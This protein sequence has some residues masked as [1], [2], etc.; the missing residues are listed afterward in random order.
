MTSVLRK[1]PSVD[2]LLKEERVVHWLKDYP[3]PLVLES[4]REV[5]DFIRSNPPKDPLLVD[6]IL[7]RIY[8]KLSYFTSYTLKPLINATG[9][10]IH[11]N[12]GRSPL[13]ER[14]I[15]N[16]NRISRGYSNLEY[17]IEKGQ[18]G[19][20]SDH[21]KR[22][23]NYLTG[24]E[25]SCVFNNNAAA[26]LLCLSA[27]AQGAEVIVSRGELVEIGGS[28]RIPEIMALSGAVLKEVGTTNKTHL[29]DY[30]NAITPNTK[31]IL[32]VHKSNY[33][34]VGFTKEVSA[35]ELLSLNVPVMFDLGSGC[36]SNI[37]SHEPTVL[38]IIKSG[39]DIVTFS[40]DKLLGGPQAGIVA[41]RTK[42]IEKIKKHPLARAV[43][44]DKLALSALEGTL[45]DYVLCKEQEIPT[46]KMLTQSQKVLYKRAERISVALDSSE[47]VEEKAQAGG[48]SLPE[49]DLLT[50]AVV[51]TPR[52]LKVSVF[53][54]MLRKGDPPVIVRVS[55]EKIV[56]DVSTVADAEVS[57]LIGR[58][59]EL[60]E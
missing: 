42:Y 9:I 5:L 4:I 40:G 41:G 7:S 6:E 8:K 14:A 11:T 27:L 30:E 56:I 37:S 54:K 43:R 29:R 19:S 45:L 10:I 16:L 46:V 53:E 38:D 51:F 52:R 23:L 47:I 44:V 13:S 12:L 21:A 24:A 49:E 28:F 26:V 39:V 60:E 36:L 34:I 48:G 50:Y 25:D 59:K 55:K 3:Q 17:N 32:K 35:Q 20:R 31:L 22:F 2:S 1:L 18:R 33:K 57:T 58:V 15:D